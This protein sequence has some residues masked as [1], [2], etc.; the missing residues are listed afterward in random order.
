MTHHKFRYLYAKLHKYPATG[1]DLLH[2]PANLP[3]DNSSQ[4]WYD[5]KLAERTRATPALYSTR[6]LVVEGISSR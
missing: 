4:S 3:T 6:L 5:M 1:L 2:Q